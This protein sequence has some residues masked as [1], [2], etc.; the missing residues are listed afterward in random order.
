MD[1]GF[2]RNED[3]PLTHALVMKRAA[4]WARE[5]ELVRGLAVIGS[6]ARKEKR[7]DQWSDLDLIVCTRSPRALLER[8]EWISRFGPP[9]L[10]FIEKTPLGGYERRVLYENG[11]D[12]DFACLS[13]EEF[14]MLKKKPGIRS[15]FARGYSVLVDKDR[16]FSFPNEVKPLSQQRP[17]SEEDLLQMTS[18][19]LFHAVWSAKKVRRG[20]LWEAM[21]C[22]DGHMKGLLLGMIRL[23]AGFGKETWHSARFVEQWAPPEI[24]PYFKG[25]FASYGY[26]EIKRALYQSVELFSLT[27]K[28]AFA[29]LGLSWPE[30]LF[31]GTL[32][33]MDD[34]FGTW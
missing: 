28:K 18:D 7:G 15:L 4:E 17:P 3:G 22:C 25:I 29:S 16:L 2:S 20:E 32:Q 13:P 10:T 26:E 14:E 27:G 23:S 12:V 5:D 1:E 31:R 8:E 19:F 30:H 9:L 24:K 6:R 11:V 33:L 21:S 34:V